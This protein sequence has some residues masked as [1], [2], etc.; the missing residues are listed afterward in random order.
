MRERAD[1]VNAARVLPAII[2]Q[3]VTATPHRAD[4]LIALMHEANYTTRI[5]SS[6]AMLDYQPLYRVI[7]DMVDPG[8]PMTNLQ[9]V[10]C[11]DTCERL[12]L[13]FAAAAKAVDVVGSNEATVTVNRFMAA[14]KAALDNF[15]STPPPATAA[16]V[17]IAAL[18]G[19]GN[20]LNDL[21]TAI[22]NL[23]DA[24][25]G[26]ITL[27]SLFGS[28]NDDKARELVGELNSQGSIAQIAFHIKLKLMNAMLSGST[29]DDDEIA[30]L[31]IMQGAK[32]CDQAGLYQLAAAATWDMLYSSFDGDEYDELVETL[33]QPT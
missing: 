3:Y 2:Q 14:L 5:C 20:T 10:A 7:A 22:T 26:A 11:R 28:D 18:G 16:G 4:E 6:L 30:I 1:M 19:V 12:R 24:L 25:A 33:Q 32:G 29:G 9:R 15:T 21:L 27:S 17:I 31:S 13:E 8:P 23:P